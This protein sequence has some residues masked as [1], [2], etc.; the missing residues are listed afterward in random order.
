M[1]EMSYYLSK[2]TSPSVTNMSQKM[3]QIAYFKDY[4]IKVRN[5]LFTRENVARPT[6]F[7]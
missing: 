3:F 2:G 6:R 5:L 1:S 7:L 4:N